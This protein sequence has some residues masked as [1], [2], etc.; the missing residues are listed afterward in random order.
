LHQQ[1]ENIMALTSEQVQI[2]RSTVPILETH[3]TEITTH[4]YK[5]LLS[6]KPELNN[7]FSTVNQANGSQPRALAGALYAYASHLDDLG[8][9]S[10][11]IEK[12][13]Q[14][15][16][17]LYIQP[18]HYKVVGEYL[19]RA[20][21]DVLGAALTKDVLDAWEAAYWQLASIMIA[22]EDQITKHEKGDWL[23]WRDFRIAKK[24]KESAE[25]TSFY[26]QPTDGKKLPSYKPGQY[27]SIKTHVPKLGYMQPR[28]YSLSDK[29]SPNYYRISVKKETGL[30]TNEPEAVV[31]PGYISNV[32]HDEMSEGD[33]LSVSHPAG[34]F[35]HDPEV[36]R[37]VPVVLLSAGVGLTPMVS[38]LNTLLD[39][40]STQRIS[41]IHGARN[42][43]VRAFRE[44]IQ[45]AAKKHENVTAS[46]F[47]GDH[48][49]DKDVEGLHYH[50][51]GRVK[52]DVLDRTQDL[53]LENEN[54]KYFV[55]GPEGFMSAMEKQ[56]LDFGVA[57]ERINME[58]FGTG[59]A[60]RA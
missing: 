23:Y 8:A 19:L 48:E 12:I 9:L 24:A 2:V 13:C 53:Q 42:T 25:I 20:M 34:E 52:L 31:H 27:I 10:P 4:F 18:D 44:H 54:T 58:V 5:T 6:E 56:L 17:S 16:V 43:S 14:K 49:Q 40:G 45:A 55:C 57:P 46:F 33:I 11:T 39:R 26:L 15:H 59:D 51:I 38:I 32:L 36:D 29:P 41:F 1:S 37:D 60:V 7:I 35:F 21:G 50:H 28:Q 30:P 22:K 3:G 47:I